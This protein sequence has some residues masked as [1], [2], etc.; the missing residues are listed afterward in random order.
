MIARGSFGDFLN[1]LREFESGVSEARIEQ[2]RAEV[3]QQVGLDRFNAFEAGEL[4]LT[5]LQYSSENFL[6]FVGYQFGEPILID[7]GYY[8]FDST[9]GANDF[10][11]TFTGK[12]GVNSLDDLKT[13]IQEQVILDEF[14]LNLNRIETGLGNAGQS[15]DDFIGR[16]ITVTDTDG[17]QAQVELTLTGILASAHLRGAFGTLDFLLNNVASADEIGTSN[18][19]F[20]QQFGGFEAP[21][22]ADLRAGNV[23]PLVTDATLT[24]ESPFESRGDAQPP[25]DPVPDPVDPAPV[26][27]APV[28]PDPQPDPGPVV[29]P[30]PDPAPAPQPVGNAGIPATPAGT[31]DAPSPVF[32]RTFDPAT[33]SFT[34]TG[35]NGI[36]SASYGENGDDIIRTFG[37]NDSSIGFAGNDFQ[38]LGDGDDRGWG[39][40]GD[41]ILLGGDGNDVLNGDEGDARNSGVLSG[42]DVLIGGRGDDILR[43]DTIDTTIASD[44]FVFASGD[45]NDIIRDFQVALDTLDFTEFG[46]NPQVALSQQGA[47]TVVSVGNVTVRLEGVDAE[48]LSVSN[49]IGAT[50]N[51]V[52]AE[53][54]DPVDPDPVDPDPVDPAP[55]PDSGP[56]VEPA[57]DPEPDPAPPPQ[58]TADDR[59]VPELPDGAPQAPS[60]VFL[61][62]FDA[63]NVSFTVTGTDGVDSAAYGFTGDDIIRSFGG[64]DS[65]VGFGGNDFQDLGAGDDRGWGLDGDDILLGGDGNDVLNGDEGDALNSGI[66]SGSDVLVGGRGDDIL[67]GDTIDTNRASDRFVFAEGDGNDIIKDFQTDLDTLDFTEFGANTD[68]SVTQRGAD[69]VV[70][71]GDVTVTLEGVQAD[72]LSSD[73]FLGD[74]G[75]DFSLLVPDDGLGA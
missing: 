27:P 22:V 52:V 68:A 53:A 58:Q 12:N 65:S 50:F 67:R 28:D 35:T 62:E 54:P 44:R 6:G 69:A 8:E 37:G 57:P 73:N 42:S 20:I 49:F 55:D 64:N 61:R 48:T 4:T 31:P 24:I 47:D 36:D 16:T 19:Q 10:I 74:N 21:S 18:V 72:T 23:E 15:L 32:L 56:V 71:V 38:D 45:G 11:G 2:N 63:A 1:A 17:S 13:N 66:A 30:D 41:D 14:Q 34:V 9:P 29:Q 25:V 33:G 3:V 26:D 40:E 5:D 46:D 59:G 51:G 75:F 43:G 70:S 60:P 39:L 7:L